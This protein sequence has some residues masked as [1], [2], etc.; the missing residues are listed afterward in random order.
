MLLVPV[1]SLSQTSP[2]V[3]VDSSRGS[4]SAA[5]PQGSGN[6]RPVCY[7]S[8]SLLLHLFPALT[9][10]SGDGDGHSSTVLGQP[11][12]LSVHS[13]AFHSPCPPQAPIVFR[14]CV[15]SDHSVLA[16]K[17]LISGSAGPRVTF[18]LRPHLLSQ[19]R[20]RHSHRGLLKLRLHA[21]RLSSNLP[22]LQDSPPDLLLR[23]A[24]LGVLPLA[25]F[26]G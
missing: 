15:D 5:P 9:R 19:P 22:G 11:S 21:W 4:L 2:W 16:S 10:S 23:L 17:A 3:A 26:T 1:S 7:L 6:D 14:N 8:K 18:P 20:S 12:G 13:L 25:P 24:W